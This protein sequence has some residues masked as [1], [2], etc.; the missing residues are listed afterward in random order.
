MQKDYTGMAQ[1]QQ[2]PTEEQFMN[3]PFMKQMPTMEQ[4]GEAGLPTGDSE[5][6]IKQR[7]LAMFEQIGLLELYNTPEKQQQF[8][9]QL[10]LLVK[11]YIAKDKKAIVENPLTKEMSQLLEK[12]PQQAPTKD[13]ASMMPGGGMGGR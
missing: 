10:D 6:D 8:A 4:M 1:K 13:Y 11:A 9:Q 5:E 2:K 7:L 12:Q 3:D